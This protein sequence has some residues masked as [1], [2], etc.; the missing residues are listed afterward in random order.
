MKVFFSLHLFLVINLFGQNYNP[1]DFFPSS[2]GNVWDY[3]NNHR[4]TIL[5]DSIS[6][7]NSRFLWV[8]NYDAPYYKID[9]SFNVYLDPI[10]GVVGPGLNWLY[11]KLDSDSGDYWIVK[12][13]IYTNGTDTV[14]VYKLAEVRE[15]YQGI[16][17]DH[18]TTFKKIIF[19]QEQQDSVVNLL[20]WPEFSITLGNGLGEVVY[21]REEG[22][23]L[24]M[25]LGCI[26]NGDTIGV[27]MSS[28]SEK[29]LLHSFS[30]Y[31]NYPNPFNSTTIIQYRTKEY[32]KVILK[33][34]SPL[35]EELKTL[36]DEFQPAGTYQTRFVADELPGGVYIYRLT[37]GNQTLSK[38]MLLI[39]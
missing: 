13:R 22:G 5:R 4:V 8:P 34:F 19:Y 25:L 36:I 17:Y 10:G 1:Y 37:I 21:F 12:T 26:I 30:L 29:N 38:K 20:S 18:V 24:V 14:Y 27:I 15:I 11:F 32:E 3:S 2:V 39:K 31:Q 9:T 35:G 33:I 28:D 6:I 7:D 16:F 23:P